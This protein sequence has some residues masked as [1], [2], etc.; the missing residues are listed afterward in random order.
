[1]FIIKRMKDVELE[2]IVDDIFEDHDKA[3]A[4]IV[5]VNKHRHD[6]LENVHVSRRVRINNVLIE[7]KFMSNLK[8]FMLDVLK[9]YNDINSE[10]KIY[11]L[12]KHIVDDHAI[13]LVDEKQS[14]HDS[15]YSMFET[16]LKMFKIYL[17]KY[18]AN[19]YI[20]LFKSSIDVS[21]LF[22][23]KKN[24]SLKLCVDY[25][26]LNA[27]IIK[28]RYFLSFIEESL[29]RLNRVKRFTSLNLTTTYHRMRIKR[30]DE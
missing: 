22:M 24:D 21:I 25:R 29:D 5:R 20:R 6:V 28:N 19:E 30:D 10:N 2:T 23:R 3:F 15:I 1:M 27:I 13:E 12:S 4:M 11:E 7:N 17:D 18:F 14:S 26:D 8:T 16:K 9:T